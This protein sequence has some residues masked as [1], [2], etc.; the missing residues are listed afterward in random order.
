MADTPGRY[1]LAT[2]DGQSIP[3]DVLYPHSFTRL[4]FNSGSNVSTDIP[5]DAVLAE[6]YADNKCKICLG[7]ATTAD[8]SGTNYTDEYFIPANLTTER[9]VRI[10]LKEKATLQ[11]WGLG[12]AGVLYINYLIPWT[13]LQLQ[14]NLDRR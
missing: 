11:V 13:S 6:I 7:A 8:V 5:T 12:A 14:T 9:K 2:P 4:A 3:L 10:Y 1:P